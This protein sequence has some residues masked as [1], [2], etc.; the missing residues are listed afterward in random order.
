MKPRSGL[1]IV[2]PPG[3][4]D[5]HQSLV[6]RQRDGT[7]V[8]A[9]QAHDFASQFAS[10]QLAR[11]AA[12]QGLEPPLPGYQ[13]WLD[14]LADFDPRR[15]FLRPRLLGL[16]VA[17]HSL[18]RWPRYA[19]GFVTTRGGPPPRGGSRP[20]ASPI[21]YGGPPHAVQQSRLCGRVVRELTLGSGE[22]PVRGLGGGGRLRQAGVDLHQVL[23]D[24]R[25][26]AAV[27]GVVQVTACARSQVWTALSVILT[28]SA[29]WP[30]TGP[31]GW[32]RTR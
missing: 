20:T 15:V 22:E 6:I 10:D 17:R 32:S 25:H 9:G 12:R 26:Q 29:C 28:A 11:H 5:G 2:P 24:P 30:V 4:T 14:R 18:P 3:H 16:G 13:R 7:V 27:E 19:S 21:S 23:V 31:N 1:R 8:L